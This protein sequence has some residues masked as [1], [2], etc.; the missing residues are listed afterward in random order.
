MSYPSHVHSLA[1]NDM[2]QV[3]VTQ[4]R[5]SCTCVHHWS[6]NMGKTCFLRGVKR[7]KKLSNSI[8]P[9]LIFLIEVWAVITLD[10]IWFI[11]A[12]DLS[13]GFYIN[14]C[15]MTSGY[16][17]LR[18]STW[19]SQRTVVAQMVSRINSEQVIGSVG[20]GWSSAISV[21]MWP[22]S[23]HLD[24]HQQAWKQIQPG[25]HDQNSGWFWGMTDV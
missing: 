12:H 20:R 21:G 13:W 2:H 16:L 7:T 4:A 22:E 19:M 24:W 14:S 17:D 3:A 11:F 15:L 25:C 18:L 6:K 23:L 5:N 9:L 10:I 8:P 1:I